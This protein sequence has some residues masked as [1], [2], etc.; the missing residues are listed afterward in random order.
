MNVLIVYAHEE[1]R[2]FNA[3]MKNTAIR[4]FEDLGHQ[5]VVSDLYRMGFKAVA[6][7]E[8]F[9]ERKDRHILVRQSEERYSS[10]LG[11]LAPDILVEQRKVLDCQLLIFQFPLWWFSLPAI[12]KGWTDRVLSM[13]FAYDQDGRWY[14][15]GGLKGRRAMLSLTT[16]DPESCFTPRG[17]HGSM[18]NLLWPIQR[19]T[20]S[21]CGFQVLPPFIGYAV[22][23]TSE[24]E[25]KA[26]LDRYEERLRNLDAVAPLPFHPL[27]HFGDGHQLKLEFQS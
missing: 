20:L 11:T 7:S 6:D 27:E 18:D 13:G 21:H 15:H 2:S 5:V 8:D 25:R 17:I 24:A 16:G 10:N 4:T 26:I 22:A 1:P 12:L 14:D 23:R 3:A 19:A 9:L